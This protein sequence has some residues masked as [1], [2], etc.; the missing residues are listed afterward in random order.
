ME[1]RNVGMYLGNHV[2]GV[3]PTPTKSKLVATGAF[4]GRV[5]HEVKLNGDDQYPVYN[6]RD[7]I[8]GWEIIALTRRDN[9]YFSALF[10]DSN[11]QLTINP[12]S[13]AL[14]TRDAGVV[15]SWQLFNCARADDGFIFLWLPT[16]GNLILRVEEI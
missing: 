1:T 11:R 5:S 2:I 8:G 3:S 9:G 16:Q 13:N 7:V 6:D 14:E 4:R 10:I 12:I 15:E